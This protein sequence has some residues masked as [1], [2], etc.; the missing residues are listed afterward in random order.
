[1]RRLDRVADED[2]ALVFAPTAVRFL[3]SAATAQG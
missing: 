1:M 3:M 2:D